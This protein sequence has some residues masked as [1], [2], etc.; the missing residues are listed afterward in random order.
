M[1][2]SDSKL[3]LG[4]LAGIAVGA[5]VG[6]LVASEKGEE[7]LDELKDLAGKAKDGLNSALEKAKETGHE[8]VAAIKEKK[9][10][11]RHTAADGTAE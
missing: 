7:L 2:S 4:L 11:I 9:S 5:A 6:Y 3:L 1:K 10:E 8:A